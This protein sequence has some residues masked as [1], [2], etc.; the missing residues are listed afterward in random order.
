[1]TIKNH[2]DECFANAQIIQNLPYF[3]SYFKVKFQ[4]YDNR[5]TFTCPIHQS[6]GQ[7]SACIFKKGAKHN[8]NFVCWTHHCE[9]DIGFTAYALFRHLVKK[10]DI[11]ITV[12]GY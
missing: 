12:V 2:F 4:E 8:G 9:Q 3:L 10:K 11:R 1:M 7:E 5:I 6:D